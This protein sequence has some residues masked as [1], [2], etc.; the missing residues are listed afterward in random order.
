MTPEQIIE[1]IIRRE[2][3]FVAHPADCREG[4]IAVR[5]AAVPNPWPEAGAVRRRLIRGR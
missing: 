3:G 2:G 4:H 5:Q 1:E